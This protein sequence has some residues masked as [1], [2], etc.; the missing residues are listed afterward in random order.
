M[1]AVIIL[2]DKKKKENKRIETNAFSKQLLPSFPPST[3][4]HIVIGDDVKL[5]GYSFGGSCRRSTPRDA[6]DPV[7]WELTSAVGTLAPVR[8]VSVVTTTTPARCFRRVYRPRVPPF[9]ETFFQ[10][11]SHLDYPLPSRF[12]VPRLVT[13]VTR[14]HFL[15][16]R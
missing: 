1:V 11:I 16:S 2:L 13:V 4:W 6:I 14:L 8:D 7:A 3:T 12:P 9:S 5:V 15:T 10:K